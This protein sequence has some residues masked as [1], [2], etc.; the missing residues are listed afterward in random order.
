[1]KKRT[2][3]AVNELLGKPPPQC[4]MSDS[5]QDRAKAAF[6]Q[7]VTTSRL[8]IRPWQD[9]DEKAVAD[10]LNADGGIFPQREHS[11]FYNSS[12]LFDET[13]VRTEVFAV[14]Q[15]LQQQEPLLELYMFRDSRIV[16]RIEFHQDPF[17]RHRVG[18][19]VL[20]SERRHGYAFE[21]YT[22]CIDRAINTG[23]LEGDLYAHTDPDN[24]ISQRFLEK[25]GFKN[26]GSKIAKNNQGED[27]SVI[28][29][30]RLLA[31]HKPPGP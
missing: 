23:F 11:Y 12:R 6:A 20:P 3:R 16:G 2:K 28:A 18:Y 29:F 21:A 8:I 9:G 27:I 26:L 30:S 4:G 15:I 22:A 1:M 17:Q 5:Y 13:T 25:A 14:M 31:R 24:L 10:F 19:F 7:P